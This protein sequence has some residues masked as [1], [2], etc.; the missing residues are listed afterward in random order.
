[1]R[2]LLIAII[3]LAIA[4]PCYGQGFTYFKKKAA[5]G[6]GAPNIALNLAF[7]AVANGY[8]TNTVITKPTGTVDGDFIL[9]AVYWFNDGTMTP[10]AGWST[11]STFNHPN[12]TFNLGIYYKRASS[13]GANWTF[14]HT[15]GLYTF[16]RAWRITGVVA[17]GD[18]EDC[19][20]S[21]NYQIQDG[22]TTTWTSITTAT[23]GA[24]VIG[25]RA[26]IDQGLIS[27]STLT[28]RVDTV[29]LSVIADTQAS[30]GAS[31]NKTATDTDTY[32]W[33]ILVLLALKPA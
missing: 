19:T 29:G 10:A 24:A 2:R 23:N 16:A 31:G 4:F 17:S 20:R 14:T 11:I 18:P 15:D 3:A 33:R 8:E 30:A 21:V 1:M 22:A 25:V 6:G 32:S 28:E 5:A 26:N 12:A 13:E 9:V 27:A 7:S